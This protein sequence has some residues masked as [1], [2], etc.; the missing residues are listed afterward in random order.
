[1]RPWTERPLEEA[2]LLNPSF[3]ALL[4]AT[5]VQEYVDTAQVEMPYALTFLVLPVV[6]HKPTREALP[7]AVS[8]SLASWIDDHGE[9]TL[10]FPDRARSLASFTREA[11]L[12]GAC[13]LILQVSGGGALTRGSVAPSAKTY[14]GQATDEVRE[15]FAKARFVGRWFAKAGNAPTVMALWGVAP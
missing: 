5:T 11:L 7:R 2:Y 1:M 12:F 15:C 14:L 6:L 3:C 8:T 13:R 10:R 4:L 9:I